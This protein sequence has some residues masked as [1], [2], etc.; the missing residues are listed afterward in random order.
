MLEL[1][2]WAPFIPN[3]NHDP[4]WESTELMSPGLTKLIDIYALLLDFVDALS[5][6]YIINTTYQLRGA[7]RTL[8][9]WVVTSL[10][11]SRGSSRRF[12]LPSSKGVWPTCY[13]L[14]CSL[15]MRFEDLFNFQPPAAVPFSSAL[16]PSPENLWGLVCSACFSVWQVSHWAR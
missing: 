11:Y 15:Q 3:S 10:R 8:R 13:S 4:G 2:D 14:F 16:L 6:A 9:S 7:N 1:C 12:V 5:N